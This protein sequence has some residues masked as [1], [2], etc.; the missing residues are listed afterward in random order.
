MYPPDAP[1]QTTNLSALDIQSN[2]IFQLKSL[3]KKSLYVLM[4]FQY[5]INL[6][7]RFYKQIH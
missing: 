4:P 6:Y 5:I 2:R 1:R 7:T 3:I